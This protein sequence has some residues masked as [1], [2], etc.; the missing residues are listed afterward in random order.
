MGSSEAMD[1]DFVVT[2]NVWK[3][4]TLSVCQTEIASHQVRSDQIESASHQ[5]RSDQIESASRL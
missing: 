2:R 5:V 4:E 1:F 3:T